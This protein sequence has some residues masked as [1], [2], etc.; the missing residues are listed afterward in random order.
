MYFPMIG[1]NFSADFN[2]YDVAHSEN[3]LALLL[4]TFSILLLFVGMGVFV[5]DAQKLAKQ[6][7]QPLDELSQQVRQRTF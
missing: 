6:I 5:A 7:H 4:T 1:A 2:D 3:R